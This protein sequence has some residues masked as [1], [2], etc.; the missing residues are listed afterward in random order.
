MK[1]L[2]EILKLSAEFLQKK[3][4]DRPRRQVEELLSYVLKLPRI[5]LYMQ[6]DRPM[7]EQELIQLR[8]ALKRRAEGEPWQYI[9][10][11]VEFLGCRIKVTKNVLIPRQE[12]EILA[13]RILKELPST[14]VEIWDVCTGSGCIGIALKKKRPDCKVILSDISTEALA[15]A[16]ENAL[17][18]GVDVELLQGDLLKPFQGK[19]DIIVC[20][21]PYISEKEFTQLDREVCEWEPKSALVGG[22]SGFEFYEKLSVE[23]PRYLKP[24]GKVYFEI[25]TGMG[26]QVKNLFQSSFWK[27]QEITQDWSSHDRYLVVTSKDFRE[28]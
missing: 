3:G 1:T 11:E 15:L 4:I 2:N 13:D 18:N 10:G 7:V 17:Q 6:Y 26:D 9:A 20:N 25:G 14:P 8:E 24:S 12:T 28:R 23:L 5:E 27:S 19:A 22:P 21:P 16:R